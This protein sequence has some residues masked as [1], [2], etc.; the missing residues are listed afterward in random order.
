MDW[1]IAIFFYLPKSTTEMLVKKNLPNIS[2][3]NRKFILLE[4]KNISFELL[5]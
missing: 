4:I 2:K 3:I 1:K 5:S